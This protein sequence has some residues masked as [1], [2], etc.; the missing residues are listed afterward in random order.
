[1]VDAKPVICEYRCG[2]CR[3][4]WVD[5]ESAEHCCEKKKIDWTRV[6][7]FELKQVHLDLLKR[8]Y[9]DW[10][11]CE[12]GAPCIGCKRPYGNS[13]VLDDIAEIIK[14]KKKDNWDF[15]EE[16]WTEEAE[17]MMIDLHKQMQVVLQI[18]LCCLSFKLGWY[19]KT[20]EY[21]TDWKFKEKKISDNLW[22]IPSS[23]DPTKTYKVE[24]K[25]GKY[26]CSCPQFIM[27]RV[28]CKH[29]QRLKERRNDEKSV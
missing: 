24:F 25:D 5:K 1:M 12:F 3:T 13:D 2:K 27:R 11:D 29:I 4:A 17:D 8:M 22:E 20:S 28:E 7:S 14:L 10:D 16:N 23:S 6:K 26:S 9:V 19:E 18:V 15:E 21:G